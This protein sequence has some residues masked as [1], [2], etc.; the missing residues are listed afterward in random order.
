MGRNRI[1]ELVVLTWLVGLVGCL[2]ASLLT[3]LR[4]SCLTC[5]LAWMLGMMEWNS[6]ARL[7]WN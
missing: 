5:F 3:R 1:G 7:G 6:L 4:A 2:D